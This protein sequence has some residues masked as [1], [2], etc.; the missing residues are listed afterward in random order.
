MLAT[1]NGELFL[2]QQIESILA[3]DYE[4][5][6][7]AVRDDG[8]SDGTLAIIRSFVERDPERVVLLEDTLGN[9]GSTMNFLQ[10]LLSSSADY[11][12]L[13]DQDDVWLPGKVSLTL[14]AMK[15]SEQRHGREMPLL[16]HTDLM[17]VDRDLSVL[18]KSFW[19]YQKI[20]PE[21]DA[22]NRLLV[23]NVV[24]GCTVM[25]NRSLLKLLR[26]I[27]DGAIMH[28]WWLALLAASFGRIGQVAAPTLFYRQHGSNAVGAIKWNAWAAF[29]KFLHYDTRAVFAVNLQKTRIQAARF[30]QVYGALLPRDVAVKISSYATL[31]QL[32]FFARLVR[33]FRFRFFKNGIKRN[34]GMFLSLISTPGANGASVRDMN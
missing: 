34:L 25:V 30:M 1:F 19:K 9:L 33:I 21:H 14:A 29:R 5:L 24:T 16:V 17:V 6:R 3:Q 23:Q 32:N 4:H 31:G 8:S 10:L 27:P 22:I 12:M 13:S 15:K 11:V 7:L 28:D 20:N 2:A 18:A 26:P